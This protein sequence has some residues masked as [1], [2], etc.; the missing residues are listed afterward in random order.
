M[1]FTPRAR[2]L[3]AAA[4]TGL[5]LA[6]PTMTAAASASSARRTAQPAKGCI[7][8]T[9]T[10][11]VGSLPDAVAA[12]PRTHHIYVGNFNSHA[13]SVISARTNTVTATIPVSAEP[14]G[15]AADP[16]TNTIYVTNLDSDLV[17]VISGRT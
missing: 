10:H 16:K 7:T 6:A 14:D 5:A 1:R 11:P 9:D 12:D 8:V 3:I 4:I 2:T 15:I 13:V 17:S